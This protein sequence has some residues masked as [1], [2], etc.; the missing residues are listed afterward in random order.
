[1]LINPGFADGCRFFSRSV[2][3]PDDHGAVSGW[4]ARG[5]AV[6][7]SSFDAKSAR[8]SCTRAAVSVPGRDQRPGCSCGGCSES[9]CLCRAPISHDGCSRYAGGRPQLQFKFQQ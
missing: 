2:H 5:E 6:Q 3:G 8:G 1:M 4:P 7:R 9:I